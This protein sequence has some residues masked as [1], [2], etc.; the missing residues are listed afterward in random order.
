MY[1]NIKKMKSI[2]KRRRRSSCH[3]HS[4]S[5][6]HYHHHRHIIYG[7]PI[8]FKLTHISHYGK[9]IPPYYV[10]IKTTSSTTNKSVYPP[11]LQM[12]KQQQI[13]KEEIRPINTQPQQTIPET[14]KEEKKELPVIHPPMTKDLLKLLKPEKAKDFN[15]FASL[16]KHIFELTKTNNDTQQ[17]DDKIL[18]Q[19]F[20]KE[21]K[22]PS[23]EFKLAL[24]SDGYKNDLPQT[25]D[26]N[27]LPNTTIM[28][29]NNV[30]YQTTEKKKNPE[31]PYLVWERIDTNSPSP[32]ETKKKHVKILFPSEIINS[33]TL[34]KGVEK[35]KND[36]TYIV[37]QDKENKVFHGIYIGKL[38][39]QDRLSPNSNMRKVK[40]NIYEIFAKCFDAEKL[41][42]PLTIRCNLL[43]NIK[44]IDDTDVFKRAQYRHNMINSIEI[45][46]KKLGDDSPYKL[47]RILGTKD[48][49]KYLLDRYVKY[50]KDLRMHG[51]FVDIDILSEQFHIIVKTTGNVVYKSSQSNYSQEYTKSLKIDLNV[52]TEN[53]LPIQFSFIQ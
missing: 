22:S 47:S 48:G 50:I 39:L 18:L 26:Y 34:I 8:L 36:K 30:K 29:I 10:P 42:T 44:N 51:T 4:R 7:D 23:P 14:K 41:I 45:S 32:K 52:E 12:K 17:L 28:L 11:P 49:D 43:Y 2:S 6:R 37:W 25:L 33:S 35:N 27:S 46:N 15:D 5:R 38:N 24:G 19:T 31:N 40:L 3:K 13:K 1:K 21:I 20:N 9:M 53:Q 16:I